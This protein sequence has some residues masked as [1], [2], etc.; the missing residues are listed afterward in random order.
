MKHFR[1]RNSILI[2]SCVLACAMVSC[3]PR[4]V[5]SRTEMQAVLYDLHRAEGIL[6]ESGYNS[7]H[8]EALG[9]YYEQIL[10]KHGIDQA[11]FDSS[12]VWYTHHPQRFEHIY[13]KVL[14]RLQNTQQELQNE[15]LEVNGRPVITDEEATDYLER[16]LHMML[17]GYRLKDNAFGWQNTGFYEKMQKNEEL[18]VY[19]KNNL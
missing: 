4:G 12:L 14:E 6:Q 19:I 5:L 3:R 11:V 10:E 8:D 17:D 13:P 1:L 7:G 15:L 18:F 16:Q 9:K 2:L